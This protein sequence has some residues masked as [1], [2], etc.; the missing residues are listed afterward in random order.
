MTRDEQLDALMGI[1]KR[2]PIRIAI[3]LQDFCVENDLVDT[4]YNVLS[5]R[6]YLEEQLQKRMPRDYSNARGPQ[7]FIDTPVDNVIVTDVTEHGGRVL[8]LT[9]HIG[10]GTR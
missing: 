8:L 10:R 2:N 7:R 3:H 6:R 4:A 5:L 1:M 9:D